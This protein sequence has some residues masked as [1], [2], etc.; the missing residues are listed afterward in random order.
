[1]R[2]GSRAGATKNGAPDRALLPDP[3][4]DGATQAESEDSDGVGEAGRLAHH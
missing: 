1:M 4:G 3:G 2:P